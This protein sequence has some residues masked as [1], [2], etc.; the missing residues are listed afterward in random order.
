ML[1]EHTSG[2][3]EDKPE[4]GECVGALRRSAGCFN[5]HSLF[6]RPTQNVSQQ[7][8]IQSSNQLKV[9]PKKVNAV[10]KK[11]TH[12]RNNKV[13]AAP[14]SVNLLTSIFVPMS[15]AFKNRTPQNFSSNGP[16]VDQ[17]QRWSNLPKNPNCRK[18]RP[19]TLTAEILSF[20]QLHLL[21]LFPT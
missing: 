4:T 1:I 13:N 12:G 20:F 15:T 17:S 6:G 21:R 16:C 2:S 18:F 14:T 7:S 11:S 10:H 8:S 5:Q 9:N 3:I 19:E